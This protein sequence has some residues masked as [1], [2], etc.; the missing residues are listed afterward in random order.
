MSSTEILETNLKRLRMPAV[1]ENL[2][3]R[4]K[5]AEE[6]SLGYLDFLSLLIQDE[7]DSREANNL[8]K[9]LKTGGF[10]PRMTF[11]TYE[12]RFNSE[13]IA[14]QVIRDLATC[15]FIRQKRSLVFCG[16]P[17]I[18]KTHI[19]QALGHE[20]CRRGGDALFTKTQKL[21]EA[22]LDSSYPRRVA[23]L[24]KQ[25]ERVELLIL[26]DFGFRRYEQ[27]EA[28]LL[29]S[30]ADLRLGNASTI[31]TSNRPPQDWYGVFPDPV[32]GGAILDRFV[33]GAIKL[34]VDKA[35][36]YRKHSTYEYPVHEIGS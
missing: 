12:Y 36:S 22:L 4:L 13:A 19:S 1:L 29:Y 8:N 7:I 33:S 20:I 6:T 11:E 30:L 14:P 27:R 34:I 35:K 24:W 18:G 15:M 23:R 10:S 17:G 21:L 3:L 31:I 32:I 26:D 9:R 2:D 16:P 25:L 5:E 28:E